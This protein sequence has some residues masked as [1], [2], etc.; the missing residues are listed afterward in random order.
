MF[1]LVFVLSQL[2]SVILPLGMPDYTIQSELLKPLFLGIR[3]PG[4]SLRIEQMQLLFNAHACKYLH[5]SIKAPCSVQPVTSYSITLLASQQVKDL[6][7]MDKW[8][9]NLEGGE[10]PLL[11][12]MDRNCGSDPWYPSYYDCTPPFLFLKCCRIHHTAISTC[13]NG[14]C[15]LLTADR[16]I[17]GN[18][19]LKYG[20][21]SKAT[22]NMA[23]L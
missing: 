13:P 10:K 23:L 4:V 16:H 15:V 2:L 17:P 18:P 1:I 3:F 22:T 11:C 20:E 7:L 14:S 9:R 6:L 5:G 21:T 19:L 8:I 12:L